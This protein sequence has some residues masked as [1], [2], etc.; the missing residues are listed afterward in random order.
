MPPPVFHGRTGAVL[1]EQPV[2]IGHVVETGAVAD[3]VDG[4]VGAEQQLA[5]VAD[6]HIQQELGKTLR[7]VFLEKMA[8]RR[9]AHVDEGR[10][11]ADFD[12]VV[13]EVFQDVAVH[14]LDAIAVRL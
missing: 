3:L 6:A 9:A 4:L 1:L 7:G 13:G 8:E 12:E 14:Q 2:E 5:G 11:V 10:H